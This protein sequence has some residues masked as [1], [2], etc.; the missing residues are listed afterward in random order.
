MNK[1]LVFLLFFCHFSY[2]PRYKNTEKDQEPR[3][4]RSKEKIDFLFV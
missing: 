3:T 4:G 2:N 1:S